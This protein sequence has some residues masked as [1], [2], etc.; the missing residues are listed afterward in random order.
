[1]YKNL[2]L[3]NSAGSYDISNLQTALRR[4]GELRFNCHPRTKNDLAIW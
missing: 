2:E 1:M 3:A 4:I